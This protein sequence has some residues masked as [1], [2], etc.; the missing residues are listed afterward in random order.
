MRPKVKLFFCESLLVS[1][2]LRVSSYN[3]I[4]CF[5]F[6]SGQHCFELLMLHITECYQPQMQALN[7]YLSSSKTNL[8]QLNVRE[9]TALANNLN[10]ENCPIPDS[11]K[12]AFDR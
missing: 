12:I 10:I 9:L 7:I 1:L 4:V 5:F 3:Y 11:A 2:F 8:S 6:F